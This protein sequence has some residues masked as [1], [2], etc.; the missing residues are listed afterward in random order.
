MA[1][2]KLGNV[3]RVTMRGGFYDT[4]E[5][6]LKYFNVPNITTYIDF[7]GNECIRLVIPKDYQKQNWVVVDKALH[8][9]VTNDKSFIETD[10]IYCLENSRKERIISNSKYFVKRPNVITPYTEK[11][12]KLNKDKPLIRLLTKL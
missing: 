5:Y 4:Y 7:L 6:A 8:C 9:S 10:I 3:V 12:K 1:K 2:F 11:L